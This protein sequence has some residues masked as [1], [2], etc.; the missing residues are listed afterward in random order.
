MIYRLICIKYVGSIPIHRNIRNI[1]P[2][3]FLFPSHV[4]RFRL[5]TCDESE[6]G[7][8]VVVKSW[9]FHRDQNCLCIRF[10]IPKV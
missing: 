10:A 6:G 4:R 8:G 5:T 9:C 7:H 3:V 1:H 2:H